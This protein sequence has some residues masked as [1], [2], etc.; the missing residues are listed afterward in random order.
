MPG[1][2]ARPD[3]ALDLGGDWQCLPVELEL[4]DA[5]AG[6]VEDVLIATV[7]SNP[8]ALQWWPLRWPAIPELDRPRY[9]GGDAGVEVTLNCR[10][11][12]MEDPSDD[13]TVYIHVQSQDLQRA[14]RLANRIGRHII[15]EPQ[16]V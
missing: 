8:A 10:R 6:S 12:F 16:Y 15:G 11:L 4:E 2:P 9:E 5:P 3:T 14:N 13:H 1:E 7:G